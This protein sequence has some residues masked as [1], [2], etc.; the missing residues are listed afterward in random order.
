MSSPLVLLNLATF[1]AKLIYSVTVLPFL[2]MIIMIITVV[3]MM[4]KVPLECPSIPRNLLKWLYSF[5]YLIPF[6]SGSRQNFQMA[7]RIDGH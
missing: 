5:I 2:L 3:M 6:D 4:I 1:Q 7:P